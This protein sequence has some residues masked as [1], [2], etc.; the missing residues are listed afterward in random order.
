[1]AS[2]VLLVIG[3]VGLTIAARE[4]VQQGRYA[5]RCEIERPACLELAERHASVVLAR[6][7]GTVVDMVRIDREGG[8][9]VCWTDEVIGRQCWRRSGVEARTPGAP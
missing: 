8:V 4:W 7:N 6:P 3:G 2:G 5:L 9:L 1:M